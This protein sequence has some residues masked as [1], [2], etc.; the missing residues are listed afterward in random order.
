MDLLE[1]VKDGFRSIEVDEPTKEQALKHL[2]QW[3]TEADF[4]AYRP[5]LQWLVQNKQWA[6]LLDRFYQILPS[7]PAAAAARSASGPTA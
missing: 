1:Q 5:Q 7:V 6:G 2:R 4:A 3:L